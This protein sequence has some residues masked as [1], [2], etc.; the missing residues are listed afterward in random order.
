MIEKGNFAHRYACEEAMKSEVS[1][2]PGLPEAVKILI[3]KENH[4]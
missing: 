3:L 2:S 4:A 1:P